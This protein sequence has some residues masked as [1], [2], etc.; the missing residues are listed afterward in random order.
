MAI[1]S[2]NRARPVPRPAVAVGRGHGSDCAMGGCLP[3]PRAA[4]RFAAIRRFALSLE[5]RELFYLEGRSMMVRPQPNADSATRSSIVVVQSWTEELRSR[6]SAALSAFAHAPLDEALVHHSLVRPKSDGDERSAGRKSS[7]YN[8]EVSRHEPT[9]CRRSL[10]LDFPRRMD[11][12]VRSKPSDRE[13]RCA[14]PNFD[15][16]VSR[17]PKVRSQL[18]WHAD[19][20]QCVRRS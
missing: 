12:S 6:S 3:A 5:G 11:A 8:T 2:L 15:V 7:T 20:R 1:G 19:R 17:R 4:R 10:V 13:L 14:E 18:S 9:H 16:L